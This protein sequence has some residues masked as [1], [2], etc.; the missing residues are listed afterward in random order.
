MAV[1]ARPASGAPIDSAWG[2][3]A[4]DGIVAQEIQ[5]GGFS[6]N[7][8]QNGNAQV[9]VTFPHPFA[10]PPVVFAMVN[11]SAGNRVYTAIQAITAT[12]FDLGVAAGTAWNYS[13]WYLAY[14]PR[15]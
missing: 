10:S 3:I 6:A 2:G 1:P 14:G 12:G 9:A 13:G 11:A 8:A 15:L 4:H 5:T 7:V